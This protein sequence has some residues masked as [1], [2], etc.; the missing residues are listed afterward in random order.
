MKNAILIHG[1]PSKEKFENPA[2]PKP[3]ESHWLPWVKSELEKKGI[4]TEAPDMPKPYQPTFE[5]WAAAL[6]RYHIG[7]ETSLV[8]LSAGGGFIVEWLSRNHDMVVDSVALVAPWIDPNNRYE[9]FLDDVE[10][11]ETITRRCLGGMV[12]FY[13]SR[14]DA[15][16]L[17][18]FEVLHEKL[19]GAK[20]IDIPEYG[21]YML[22]N[23]M[24]SVRFPELI[25][26]IV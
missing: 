9:D 10:I 7:V 4:P 22:G 16:A 25:D 1:K 26:E 21:H 8:G 18:S 12:I 6:D 20:V 17:Q 19:P 5:A 24:S 15:E 14:D 11:D 23:T 2:N 3:S 13:S